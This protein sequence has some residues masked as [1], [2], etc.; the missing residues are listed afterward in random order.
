MSEDDEDNG[1]LVLRCQRGDPEAFRELVNRWEARLYYYLRRVLADDNAIWD[2]LQETWLAVFRDIQALEDVRKFSAWLYQVSH[3]RAVDLR[4]RQNR[5][6]ESVGEQVADDVEDSNCSIMASEEAEIVHA[7]LDK[8]KT[9]HREVLTLRFVEDFSA[10]E[11]SEILGVSEGTVRSR[12][13]YAKKKLSA[14]LREANHE[15][16]R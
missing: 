1:V 7:Q 8:L 10:R 11:M 15:D 5:Y 13:H 3:A 2:V 12:L 16:T 6:I 4:R 14:L 9:I